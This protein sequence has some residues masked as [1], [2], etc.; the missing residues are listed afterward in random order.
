M[1]LEDQQAD[2]Q[3]RFCRHLIHENG[4]CGIHGK[5][6]FSCDFEIVRFKE[7]ATK[8]EIGTMFYGR[9]WQM[10]RVVDNERGAKCTIDPWTE[11]VRADLVRKFTRLLTWTDHFGLRNTHLPSLIEH[12]N[13]GPYTNTVVLG[14]QS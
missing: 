9:G 2:V 4:R 11:D 14:A 3:G 6:P 12:V 13:R 10:L 7:H 5:Q 1:V 8:F